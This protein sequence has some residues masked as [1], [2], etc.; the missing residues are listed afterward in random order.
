V[1]TALQN[2]K[3]DVFDWTDLGQ[4][5]LLS[6]MVGWFF[7]FLHDYGTDQITVQRLMAVRSDQ[8]VVKAIA[9]NAVND[10]II[11]GMLIFIGIG[12]F[13][14]FEVYPERFVQGIQPDGVLPFYVMHALPSGVS[15]LVITAIFAAAMSS[16]DSGIN[17]LSTVVVTDFIKPFFPHLRH[18]FSDIALA[19]QL[20]ILLGGIATLAAVYASRIGNIV[21]MWMQVMGLFAAPILAI[22]V[23]GMLTRR[24]TFKGWLI[25]ACGGIVLTVYLQ[26]TQSDR[27]MEIWYFPVSFVVTTF[28]G[29]TVS[30]YLAQRHKG[31]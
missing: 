23:L 2:G 30:F 21:Q 25:G 5:T 6:A 18:R 1:H 31:V 19:R 7:V 8:G 29:Y 15:G 26:Q 22:F 27:M 13:V 11:N 4:L 10:L 9:F 17:S 12:I 14:Y 28:I 20:T 16:V 3:F 24:A